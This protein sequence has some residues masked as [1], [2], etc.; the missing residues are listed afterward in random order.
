MLQRKALWP[1]VVLGLAVVSCHSEK[2]SP[3]EDEG[4]VQVQDETTIENQ[5]LQPLVITE[6][7]L[8]DTDDPAIWYNQEQ[9][10][11]SIVF[12]TDK[13]TE[14]A[15]YAFNLDG[16]ILEDKV[17]KGM[18]RPNNVDIEYG[19]STSE[20]AIDIL[21]FTERE[22]SM[23]RVFSVP[24][25]KPLDGGGFPVFEGEPEGDFQLP[26][27]I[28]LYKSA[29][30][31]EVYAIVGRKQGPTDG[32]YLWQYQLSSNQEG[33]LQADLVRKF[34]A[35]SGVKEIEAICA[36]D[37]R[38][39]VYYSDEMVGIRQYQADPEAGNQEL[40]LFG[41]EGFAED[42]EGIAIW[43]NAEGG[44]L[45]VSDQQAQGLRLFERNGAHDLVKDIKYSAL[46]TDGIEII[47]KP[48]NE[49]FPKGM[50]V[51]MS[52]DKTFHFYN[53][54]DFGVE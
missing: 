27:G 22:R 44:Y 1:V 2:E 30:T 13:D 7:V 37:E 51:A 47:A 42:I 35:F 24:D 41:D 9:P 31:D 12:G 29:E 20:G 45:F 39:H 43:P 4:T 21:A 17:L 11:N 40:A 10:E 28:S 3:K 18:K 33:A 14:G 5:I 50:L 49:K 52:D 54:E 36:D 6:P 26:M 38:G 19:L 32:S 25:M 23:L 46:E 8:H 15:I 34:G 16:E 48:L 53:L